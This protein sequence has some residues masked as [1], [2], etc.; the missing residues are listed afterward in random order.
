MA[1]GTPT[2]L[3][4]FSGT[5][6]P[7][8]G[9]ITTLA[10]VST[11]ALICLIRYANASTGVFSGAPTDTAGNTYVQAPSGVAVIG[12]APVL[13]IWYC[14]NAI[15]MASSSTISFNFSGSALRE[16]V[17][18]F[19]CTG[20][21][22]GAPLDVGA[23]TILNGTTQTATG[24]LSLNVRS[25]YSSEL[26]VGCFTTAVNTGAVTL[27]GSWTQVG[28]MVA[29]SANILPAYQIVSGINSVAW[30]PTWINSALNRSQGFGFAASGS[31]Y[32]AGTSE[33][34]LMGVG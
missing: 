6:T 25:L 16:A 21:D 20:L 34:T 5:T 22:T 2:D 31:A 28:G 10:A 26:I 18:A 17:T 7:T 32:Q 24:A 4:H 11:G 9:S 13:D 14:K 12:F 3:G 27:G 1:I 33:L 8:T 23:T 19:T 15:S 29:S 30:A